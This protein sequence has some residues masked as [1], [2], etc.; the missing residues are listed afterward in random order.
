[1]KTV[2]LIGGTTWLSTMDYY[3]IMN[4]EVNRQLGGLHSAK[5]LLYSID[6]EEFKTIADAGDWQTLT[7]WF[8]GI[9]QQLQDAGAEAIVL[10]AVTLHLIAPELQKLVQ[11][12][13]IHVGDATARELRAQNIHRAVL[14]G[15]KF[16]MESPFF[17]DK[18]L[19]HGVE[20]MLPDAGERQCIHQTIFDELDRGL[21]LKETK[22][23]YLA[24]IQNLVDK[25]AEGVILGCTEIPLLIKPED[26]TVP[27]FDTTLIHAK[28]A[29]R[30]ALT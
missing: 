13:I 6:F 20:V 5:L 29:A 30:F 7:D 28:A 24:I 10:C 15:T 14:L 9:S 26:C 2:G 4:Q 17:K 16:T 22:V 27:V 3:R 11:L 19:G 18:L 12:P 1:M 23:R 25:G 8:A 21:L